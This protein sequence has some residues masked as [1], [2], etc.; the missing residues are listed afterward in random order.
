MELC[1]TKR[2]VQQPFVNE[3]IDIF[4]RKAFYFSY[5][6][7]NKL[8][9]NPPTFF[10]EYVL[11]NR[12]KK[13]D[14]HLVEGKVIHALLLSEDVFD[15]DFLVTPT[16]LPSDNTKFVLDRVFESKS[17]LSEQNSQEIPDLRLQRN[18]ILS[19]LKDIGLHQSLT[20]DKPDKQGNPGKS[21]DDKRM[22]KILS[23]EAVVYWQFLHRKGTRDILDSQSL[24][25]CRRAVEKVKE[26]PFVLELLGM[27]NALENGLEVANEQELTYDL[28]NF[29]FGIKG[30]ID[31]LVFDHR[32]LVIRIN[33]IKTTS[34]ELKEFPDSV[35]YYMYWMQAV[36]YILLVL[37]NYKH[38]IDAG[39]SIEFQFIVID[40]NFN[41]YPFPVTQETIDKW[42]HRFYHESLFKAN[43]HYTQKQYKLPYEFAERLVA[44]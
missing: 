39:Y 13:T 1:S 5:S 28:K 7:L 19:L 17:K 10:Q 24:E 30:V 25:H 3:K 26:I 21:G 16:D 6:S 22:E 11:G 42:T 38:L 23:K 44:L 8:L 2:I 36:I 12:E 9:W 14:K 43:Y 18:S 32:D 34:K 15:Q 27:H 37:K 4:Y 29:P 33:D 35:Y 40:K 41:V 31:N 20:D